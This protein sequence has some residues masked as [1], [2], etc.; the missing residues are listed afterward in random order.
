MQLL[1]SLL[2]TSAS[3]AQGSLLVPLSV[4]HVN[5]MVFSVFFTGKIFISST[6]TSKLHAKWW[7]LV[8]TLFASLCSSHSLLR[9][10]SKPCFYETAFSEV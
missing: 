7:S 9:I 5:K 4:L 6:A 8:P 10:L 2:S 3:E 1:K